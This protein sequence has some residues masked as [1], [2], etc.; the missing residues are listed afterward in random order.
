MAITG[1]AAGGVTGVRERFCQTPLVAAAAAGHA[2]MVK[3]LLERGAD[4]EVRDGNGA[5]AADV[6][7]RGAFVDVLGEL[8][9]VRRGCW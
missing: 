9:R 3:L 8:A 2:A 7:K 5:T 1:A 4:P 6:A